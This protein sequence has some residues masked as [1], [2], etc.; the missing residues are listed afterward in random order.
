LPK[1]IKS[2]FSLNDGIIETVRASQFKPGTVRIVVDIKK[3]KSF[4]AFTVE[5]PHRLVIDVYTGEPRI[6]AKKDAAKKE[7]IGIKRIVIDPGHGGQDPERSGRE[8][9]VK[10][11]LFLMLARNSAKYLR[12]NITWMLSS[13]V[14]RMFLCRSMKD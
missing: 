1:K 8:V 11:I 6:T 13:H 9:S 10:K 2:S 4:Y 12:K 3:L 7:P 14:K 5:D